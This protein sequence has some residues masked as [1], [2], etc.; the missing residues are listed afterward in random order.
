MKKITLYAIA[1]LLTIAAHAQKITFSGK[2]VDEN[3]KPISFA[4][5]TILKD[6]NIVANKISA[7]DG[8]FTILLNNIGTYMMKVEH[9]S[10]SDYTKELNFTKEIYVNGSLDTQT[11]VLSKEA[12][13]LNE[14]VVT[15]KKPLIERKVD[16][17]VFN[18]QSSVAATGGDALDA[19]KVAPGIQVNNNVITMI[20][21]SGLSVMINDRMLNLSGDDLIN[22]LKSIKSEDIQSIEII[23]TPPAKY[24][25][26]GNSGI[27]NIKLKRA[28]PNSWNASLYGAYTQFQY[29][30]ANEGASFRYNKNKLSFYANVS[31]NNGTSY[32]KTENETINYPDTLYNSIGT[33]KWN[34]SKNIN[35]NAGVD[36]DFSKKLSMGVQYIYTLNNLS[37][38]QPNNTYLYSAS[39]YLIQTLSNGSRNNNGNNLNFHSMYQLDTLGRKIELNLDYFD[40]KNDVDNTFRTQEYANLTDS[41]TGSYDAANNGSNQGITNYS[42]K[43]DVT[44]PLKW[45]NLSYGGKLSFTK[46]NSSIYYYDLTTGTPVFQANRSD[47]FVYN[48]NQQALYA[49]ANKKMGKWQAQLGLRM[50]KTEAKG[51]SQTLA[52][53]YPYNYLKLFPTAYVQYA[54]N[55]KNIFSFNYSERVNRPSYYSLNPFVRYINPYSTSQGNPFLQPSYTHN[56]ELNYTYRNNWNSS[57]YFSRSLSMQ[58]QVNYISD[59]NINTSIKYENAYNQTNIGLSESYTFKQWKWLESVNTGN[60]SYSKVTSLLPQYIPGNTGTATFLE[61]QNNFILNAEKTF[62]L[63]L[64][65]WY[66]FPQY[67]GLYKLKSLSDLGIGARALLF[68]K[69]LTVAVTS[70]DILKTHKTRVSSSFSGIPTMFNNY[71]FR[72]SVRL[73]LRYTFGNSN[74]SGKRVNSGN[75]EERQRAGN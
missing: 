34:Y 67:Y 73:S 18:V 4:S 5:I 35:A 37:T 66:M 64:D 45:M 42:V 69:K 46:N 65:Y 61:T 75:A 27:I 39:N 31:H 58:T 38:I 55:T 30:N 57:I 43:I 59:G 44:H 53:T 23:T 28:Q 25:A 29:A 6:T 41:V 12:A 51:T 11:I 24:D 48:E 9:V 10:Y 22:Y 2:V 72:Q 15:A 14:V 62:S 47:D 7:E 60:V 32:Y 21:K 50:E 70:E 68:K 33:L 71:E 26:E 40:Y 74:I 36:Y 3:H 16:R 20:G 63:S 13:Q 54:L 1:A 49:S 19:L 17:L 56:L 52:E 8:S